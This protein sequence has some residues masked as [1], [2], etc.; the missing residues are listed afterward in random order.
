MPAEALWRLVRDDV[1]GGAVSKGYSAAQAR[2]WQT[3]GIWHEGAS[4]ATNRD[5]EEKL[6]ILHTLDVAGYV[7][8][9]WAGDIC[10][11]AWHR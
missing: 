1:L 7:H 10:C 8:F 4:H 9:Q 2:G 11:D 6:D 3:F 5:Y